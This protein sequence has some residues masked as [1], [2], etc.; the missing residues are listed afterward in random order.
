MCSLVDEQTKDGNDREKQKR[1]I[2]LV[3]D[4]EALT[5][6]LD[7]ENRVADVERG[8]ADDCLNVFKSAHFSAHKQADASGSQL[9][10]E[11]AD[12]GSSLVSSTGNC[13]VDMATMPAQDALVSNFIV[14]ERVVCQYI[15]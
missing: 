5:R 6:L 10:D 7:R 11:N 14:F 12:T 1:P 13:H 4:E 3:Y 15:L 8:F 9:V 2:A